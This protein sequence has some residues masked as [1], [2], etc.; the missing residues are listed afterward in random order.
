MDQN[1]FV[2]TIAVIK[3]KAKY[4][5]IEIVTDK[6]QIFLNGKY[7]LKEFCGILVQSPNSEGIIADFT[8]FFDHIKALDENLVKSIASDLMALTITKSPG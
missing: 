1:V 3:T 6:W 2:S 7:D 8:T 4:L 5:N